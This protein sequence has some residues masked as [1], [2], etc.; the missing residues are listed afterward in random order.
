M[1]KTPSASGKRSFA[2]FLKAAP[3]LDD[4][5][6][7]DSVE[8]TGLISR[9]GEG[10]FAITTP[11]GQTLDLPVD[12]VRDFREHDATGASAAATVRV[13][14]DA[15]GG[16]VIHP[17]KPV[18]KDGIKDV[19]KDVIWDGKHLHKDPILDPPKPLPKDVHKDP[20]G[21]PPKPIYDPPK[22]L[23]KDVHKDPWSDPLKHVNDPIID[24][25]Q[26]VDPA[27][28]FVIATAH[29][30][31]Q[32]LLSLQ[33]GAPAA[34]FGPAPQPKPL[35][36]TVKESHADTQKEI[37]VDTQKEVATDTR[38]EVTYDTQKEI[39][40]DTYKELIHDTRKELIVDTQ[41]EIIETVV[42]GG[43]T[44]V[45]QGG[46]PGQIYTQPGFV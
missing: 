26:A 44:T 33:T 5:A 16:A 8:L 40:H 43:G 1:A 15:L 39:I 34:G 37:I 41:K 11:D 23:P 36:D 10:R 12:A 28:P 31:P 4:A 17:K 19:I 7:D 29:Q 18:L 13:G 3:S 22:H 30:A 42:E 25:G 27:S 20:L 45:E 14:R 38:K 21:D 35:T 24:P 32:H 2:E 46:N 9:T 6:T